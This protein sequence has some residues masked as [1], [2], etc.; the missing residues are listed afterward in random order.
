MKCGFGTTRSAQSIRFVKPFGESKIIVADSRFSATSA[1]F[2]ADLNRI[3]VFGLPA[4]I[5]GSGG[6]CNLNNGETAGI[7]IPNEYLF[8]CLRLSPDGK[9][10]ATCWEGAPISLRTVLDRHAVTR[11]FDGPIERGLSLAFTPDGAILACGEATGRISLWQVHDGKLLR[12]FA[13][14]GGPVKCLAFNFDGGR[15]ASGSSDGTAKLWDTLG[16]RSRAVPQ[17]DSRS[18][19]L[20]LVTENT[21]PF[22]QWF[23]QSAKIMTPREALTARSVRSLGAVGRLAEIAVSQSGEFI[24]ALNPD[25]EP[26]DISIWDART[27]VA[28]LHDLSVLPRHR[29][30]AIC[31]QSNSACLAILVG[32]N[33]A[34]LTVVPVTPPSPHIKLELSPIN[35]KSVNQIDDVAFS[36]DGT[37]VAAALT[38]NGRAHAVEIWELPSCKA[39]RSINDLPSRVDA[40]RF[41]RGGRLALRCGR[42]IYLGNISKQ[43]KPDLLEDPSNMT[44]R[45][46]R[47][48]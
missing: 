22:T 29:C 2:S 7:A 20:Q 10:L 46:R 12:S 13:G 45:P 36:A 3:A 32:Q 40:L 18:V 23:T 11:E 15:L 25:S 9:Q 41:G 6:V 19:K 26:R 5:F 27:G 31:F 28:T 39:V 38:S 48:A 4:I 8:T 47:R 16:T 42:R 44:R 35:G 43:G 21:I 14:H 1:S 24:A 33:P 34:S 17:V 30:G 37:R